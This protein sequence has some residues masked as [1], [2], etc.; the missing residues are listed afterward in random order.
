M[1]SMVCSFFRASTLESMGDSITSSI[2]NEVEGASILIPR[3]TL[4]RRSCNYSSQY[5]L[6]PTELVP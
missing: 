3:G 5:S 2:T 1:S 4:Q 6:N